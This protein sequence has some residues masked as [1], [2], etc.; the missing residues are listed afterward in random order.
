MFD[1]HAHASSE[2]DRREAQIRQWEPALKT[3]AIRLCRNAADADDLVQDTIE[4]A[5]GAKST[6]TPDSDGR[7][8]LCRVLHNLFIDHCRKRRRRVLALATSVQPVASQRSDTEGEPEWA[9][10]TEADLQR[11]VGRL[12]PKY[13]EVYTLHCFQRASYEVIAARLGISP[14]T[15]GS[16][17][18]RARRKLRRLLSPVVEASR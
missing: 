16:R 7:A 3:M 5:L 18:S 11:A 2:R 13:R 1:G 17:L 8:W 9:R 10:L 6:W 12:A 14:A 4:R 15:V